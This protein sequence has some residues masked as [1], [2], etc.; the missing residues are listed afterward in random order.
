MIESDKNRSFARRSAFVIAIALLLAA[1]SAPA[2]Q[3]EVKL[4]AGEA[5]AVLALVGRGDGASPAD[6]QRL[7]D[8]EGYRRLKARE[9][10][11]NRAF[12]D[13]AFRAFVLSPELKR[14]AP[15]LART[16]RDLV[17]DQGHDDVVMDLAGVTFIDSFGVRTLLQARSTLCERGGRFAITEPSAAVRRILEILRLDT[18]LDI[19]AGSADS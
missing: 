17:E 14:R 4:D 15:E 5:D 3:L 8:A 6:W 1:T 10:A 9:S 7:Y 18:E 11:M 19:R 16:L 13:S 2:Q 12:T